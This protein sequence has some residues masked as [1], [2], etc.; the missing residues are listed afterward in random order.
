[1]QQKLMDGNELFAEGK[2]EDAEKCFLDVLKQ[3]PDNKEAF[4]NMGVIAFQKKRFYEAVDYFSK[5]L[6]LDHNYV[7]ANVNFCQ[8][9]IMMGGLEKTVSL[10]KEPVHAT[11]R[12]KALLDK[13]NVVMATKKKVHPEEGLDRIRLPENWIGP[14][15]IGGVGGSG[16]RLLARLIRQAGFY[17]GVAFNESDDNLYFS[18]LFANPL[19]ILWTDNDEV[20][21]HET[22]SQVF[23]ALGIFERAMFC[24]NGLSEKDLLGLFRYAFELGNMTPHHDGRRP[25]FREVV[26]RQ[27]LSMATSNN[28]DYNQYA[29]WGW[30]EPCTFIYLKHLK[31]FFPG[32]KYIHVVRHG[33]D[34]AFSAN[35]WHLLQWGWL[36]GVDEPK[37]EKDVFRSQLKLWNI[38]NRF[39]METARRILDKNFLLV[40]F[41]DVCLDTER[42]ANK[43]LRFL[44]VDANETVRREFKEMVKVPDS[45]YR[46]KNHDISIFSPLDVDGIKEFGYSV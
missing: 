32:M 5:A 45:L 30:K 2:I 44:G 11:S 28:V 46:Y 42:T 14:V 12:Q 6:T 27:F 26:S 22:D 41:E 13:T 29:G 15:V 21:P 36:F 37:G 18:N 4:N 34:M 23:E 9:L 19:R 39:T 3:D 25:V 7:D 38:A 24:K 16:T 31:R 20:E 1:M 10:L 43:V 35:V 40:R 33:L 17:T 8:L